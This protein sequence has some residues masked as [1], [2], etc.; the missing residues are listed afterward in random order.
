[1]A[2]QPNKQWRSWN[3]FFLFL[4]IG[5]FGCAP[6]RHCKLLFAIRSRS[7]LS[8]CYNIEITT[9]IAVQL[10]ICSLRHFIALHFLLICP[11]DHFCT[12]AKLFF[13][14]GKNWT[15]IWQKLNKN[16]T[17]FGRP[18]AIQCSGDHEIKLSKVSQLII[19]ENVRSMQ[20][21]RICRISFCCKIR[22]YFC[23]NSMPVD[24]VDA[25]QSLFICFRNQNLICLQLNHKRSCKLNV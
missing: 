2:H 22:C 8:I 3:S 11:T 10:H 1:M 18:L 5:H 14:G 19:T 7:N 21:V 9:N 6:V 25:F 17:K 23:R 20:K 24:G 13:I 16:L 4:P 15:K 12:A